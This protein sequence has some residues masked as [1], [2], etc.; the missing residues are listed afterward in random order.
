MQNLLEGKAKSRC[1]TQWNNGVMLSGEEV[2]VIFQTSPG[3]WPSLF[4]LQKILQ[5]LF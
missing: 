4:S 2:S 1:Q 5:H 3:S